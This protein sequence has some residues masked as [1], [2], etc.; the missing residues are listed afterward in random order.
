MIRTLETST[1][2][3]A[4]VI[5][6]LERP[7]G[8]VDPEI[9]RRVAE[10]VAAVR[11]KGDAA[12]LDF[13]RRFDRVALSAAELAVRPEEY[14]AAERAVGEVTLRSLRYA[15]D[16]IERFHRECAP[17]SWRMTRRQRLAARPG[18]APARPGRGLRA[19]RARRL[20]RPP[21]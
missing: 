21:C 3:I 4:G 5:R 19:R 6:A 9:A 8:A 10:I 13:T 14:A 16:R 20:S 1:S 11:D 15:A 2:G 12:L 18:G 17:R 7:P